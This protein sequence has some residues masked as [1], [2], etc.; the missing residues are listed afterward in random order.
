MSADS[1][2]IAN[3]KVNRP[4]VLRPFLVLLAAFVVYGLTLNHWVTFGSLPIASQITGWDWHPGPLP[5]RPAPEYQPLSLL[6]TLPLR[7]LPIA[8]RILGLNILTAACAALTLAILAR[9]VRLLPY[10][11]AKAQVAAEDKAGMSMGEAINLVYD[12]TREERL[13]EGDEFSLLSMRA[14]FLP[15]AFAVL[16][17]GFQLTFWQNAVSGTGEMIDLLVFAFLI[18]CLLEFR[19]R[20]KE[21]WL[22]CFAFVY[23]A[24]VANNWA[25]IGFFPC[26]LA[27]VIWIKRL[28]FFNLKF[29]LRTTGLGVLGLLLY[30]LTPLLGAIHHDSGFL[31]LLHQKL[32]EQYHLMTRMPRYFLLIA[33]L[34]TLIPL[35]FAAI[36]WPFPEGQFSVTDSIARGLF[37][38]LHIAFL[39]VGVLMFFDLTLSPSPRARFGLG[40]VQGPGFLTFYYLAAL[41]VGYFSGYVLLVFDR[42]VVPRFQQ[43][44]ELLRA[45]NKT[46]TGLLWAAAIGLPA[47][48]LFVNFRHIEDFNS[49]AVSDFGTEMANALPR[50]SAIVLADDTTRLYL[51]AG[52]SQRIAQTNDYIFVDSASLNHGEY[53]RYLAD[54]YPAFR[55]ELVSSDRFPE[56]I[57]D[58]QI[59]LL[60]SHLSSHQ[61]VYY[62]NPTF[63]NYC[64]QTCLM[65]NRLG[66]DLSPDPS[67]ALSR[68]VLAPSEITRNQDY[69]HDLEKGPL[70]NLARIGQQKHGRASDSTSSIRKYLIAG[71]RTFKKQPRNSSSPNTSK[72]R[73]SPTQTASLPKRTASTQIISWHRQISR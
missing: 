6:L 45:I 59:G 32:A 1:D 19:L 33:A 42:D 40:E 46:V 9:S 73:C 47:I 21:K 3:S 30:G 10:D 7:L 22:S 65:P 68:L 5:W 55:K 70:V 25:L 50:K 49:R 43:P 66:Q 67:N 15:A 16:L 17:L 71:V 38:A 54:R 57:T 4:I 58:A 13:R 53:L 11:R 63:G 23:G 72:N 26:F 60:L 44:T 29:L 27:A 34:P 12:R 69:W 48:L 20:Q 56:R 18:L 14:A 24:G 28:G 52:G 2:Q 36:N 31:N 41:S 61:P 37:R 8:W 64:E 62:L 35:L 39:A 51:A